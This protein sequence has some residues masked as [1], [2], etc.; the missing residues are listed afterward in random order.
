VRI[1]VL[2]CGYWGSKHVRVLQGLPG[3]EAVVA[4]DRDVDRLLSLQKV[5]PGLITH[6][7]IEDALAIADAVVVATPPRSHA[8]LALAILEAGKHVLVEKPLATSSMDARLLVK[9]AEARQLTLMVGHTFEHNAAVWKLRELIRSGVVGDV[10]YVD[11]ARLNLGLYQPDV[12][13][14]WDLAPH[15]VSI[16]NFV[17][18]STPS[19]V[20]AWG[21]THAHRTLE[22]V[23]YLRLT[24]AAIDVTAHAHVS[25]LDPCKVRRVTVVGT[26]RMVVYNDLATEE[27]IRIYDKGVVADGEADADTHA[28]ASYRYGDISSPFVPFEEP[29]VVQDR[30]FVEASSG[31]PAP[32]SQP[33]PGTVVVDVLECAERSMRESRPV[34][35][36]EVR[37][38]APVEAY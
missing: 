17:L 2:G 10:L 31:G 15:D 22:D 6:T 29:L 14:I 1:A 28:P 3:V 27:R 37:P 36:D 13:V 35:L 7:R 11:S 24:Y 18:A 21:S 30:R 23:A 34:A 25:W 26:E 12:N 38:L 20:H 19:S 5:S 32:P 9:T 16:F 4:V 33:H 8:P